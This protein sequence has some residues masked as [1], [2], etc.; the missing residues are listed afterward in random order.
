MMTLRKIRV[1]LEPTIRLTPLHGKGFGLQTGQLADRNMLEAA[2]H[3]PLEAIDEPSL[4]ADADPQTVNFDGRRAVLGG[5][6][7]P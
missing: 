2:P 6:T 3:H 4:L 7:E 1:I 5:M